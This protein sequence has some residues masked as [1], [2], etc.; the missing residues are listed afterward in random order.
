[1]TNKTKQAFGQ[2]APWLKFLAILGFVGLGVIFVAGVVMMIVDIR[3]FMH[4][5]RLF[6]V[7]YVIISVVMFFPARWIF[8]L[9]KQA[10]LCGQEDSEE[11]LEA[12]AVNLH[13]VVK[14]YGIVT[15]VFLAVYVVAA[16]GILLVTRFL[17]GV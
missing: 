14:F 12:L 17:T 8:R 13:R 10:K 3:P 11:N 4:W 7:L 2:T 6:G 15:I 1:M 16:V 9:S 5:G